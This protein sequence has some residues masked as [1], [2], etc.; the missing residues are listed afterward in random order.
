LSETDSAV[1]KFPQVDRVLREQILVDLSSTVRRDIL[2]EL[3]REDLAAHREKLEGNKSKSKNGAQ[4]NIAQIDPKQ[5]ESAAVA[6]RVAGVARSL[7]RGGVRRVINGTGVILNTNLGRAP[8]PL[9]TLEKLTE[10]G[11]GYTSLEFDL[12]SGKRGERTAMV[13]RLLGLLTGSESAIVVNNNASAVMLAVSALARGKEVI[14]SRG[15]LIEI[16]G[17]FRLPDVITAAGGMLKEVG[18]TNR[19]RAGDYLNAISE[20]T[21]M[22]MRCHRSNFEITGFTEEAKLHELVD[23]SKAKNIPLV[24]DLGSG[25]LFDISKLGLAYEPTVDKVIDSGVSVVMFSGD[26]LLGGPQAGIIAGKRELV[27]KLRKDPMYRALR[28]DKLIIALLEI[29]LAQYLSPE[30]TESLPV[31]NIASQSVDLIK[32][33]LERF[34]QQIDSEAKRSG[35]EFRAVEC[36]STLGGGSLPGKTL[37][38][39]ALEI[40]APN[41][42]SARISTLLR[43]ADPA[44]ISTI[45]DEKVLIDFRTILDRDETDL[46]D[47]LRLLWS[48]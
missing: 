28:A 26:K 37:P 35:V 5:L 45:Q 24:E 43:R 21:G 41:L 46:L 36:Q 15:E 13:S 27:S 32:S 47:A 40:R 7:L 34:L 11:Q 29:V 2:A 23:I 6:N 17:S 10:L 19:T 1:F 33:R 14:V 20:K 44:V 3:V 31:I 9:A 30:P 22:M 4:S 39:F 18:T 16:G 48:T 38:S 12:E 8:L 42:T 25:A